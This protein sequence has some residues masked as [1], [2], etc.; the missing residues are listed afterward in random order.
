ME[1]EPAAKELVTSGRM[2]YA[3]MMIKVNNNK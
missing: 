1:D 3:L 2:N